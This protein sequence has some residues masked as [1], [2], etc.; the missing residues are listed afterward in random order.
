M[1]KTNRQGKW[2][3]IKLRLRKL[4]YKW[5]KSVPYLRLDE[6]KS[7]YAHKM[8]WALVVLPILAGVLL[9]VWFVISLDWVFDPSPKGFDWIADKYKAPAF[10]ITLAGL[11]SIAYGRLHNSKVQAARLVQFEKSLYNSEEAQKLTAESIRQSKE[12]FEETQRKNDFDIRF[13]HEEE[14]LKY[15]ERIGSHTM[16]VFGQRVTISITPTANLYKTLFPDNSIKANDVYIRSNVLSDTRQRVIRNIDRWFDNALRQKTAKGIFE[17]ISALDSKYFI[18]IKIDGKNLTSDN[19]NNVV[20]D[21]RF[22]DDL[23]NAYDQLWLKVGLFSGGDTD[24][25]EDSHAMDEYEFS[26]RLTFFL[27]NPYSSSKNPKIRDLDNL[28][29]NIKRT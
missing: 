22:W 1:K 27:K 19:H 24:Y 7:I 23:V 11:F 10:L 13:K 17:L 20:Y 16:L 15:I 26:S 21:F 4:R 5:F 18:N 12:A 25:C 29:V 9:S 2:K 14:F 28:L 8:F 6:S 3:G